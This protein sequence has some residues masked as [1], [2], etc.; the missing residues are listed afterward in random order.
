LPTLIIYTVNDTTLSVDA[1][2][3]GPHNRDVISSFAARALVSD[4]VAFRPER[5]H[6]FDGLKCPHPRFMH[7]KVRRKDSV[8][9]FT[10]HGGDTCRAIEQLYQIT[11]DQL[12]ADD[13]VWGDA[14][15]SGLGSR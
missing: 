4:K 5:A 2:M 9:Q 6:S 3:P 7:K 10:V 14:C 1:Q 12:V 8:A 15:H 11:M 13:R